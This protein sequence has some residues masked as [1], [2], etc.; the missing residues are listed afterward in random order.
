[1]EKS[2]T[3]EK[4]YQVDDRFLFFVGQNAFGKTDSAEA[5]FQPLG[6]IILQMRKPVSSNNH[7][8]KISCTGTTVSTCVDKIYQSRLEGRATKNLCS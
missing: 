4:G 3:D 8:A 2:I 7:V 5:N 6:A 1:L